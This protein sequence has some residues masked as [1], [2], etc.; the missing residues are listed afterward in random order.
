MHRDLKPE[1]L[2]MVSPDDDVAFKM[3]D[4]GFAI[5]NHNNDYA[6][7]GSPSYVAPEILTGSLYDCKVDIWSA[8]VMYVCSV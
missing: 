8:G 3:V 7:C 1:N 5:E 2:L 4:F 6:Q